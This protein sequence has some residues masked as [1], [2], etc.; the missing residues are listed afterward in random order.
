[1]ALEDPKPARAAGSP[2]PSSSDQAEER[3]GK[4]NAGRPPSRARQFE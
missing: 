3:A 2:N 4:L 1:M